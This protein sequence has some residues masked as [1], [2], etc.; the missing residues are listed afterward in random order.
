MRNPE[1]KS[2]KYSDTLVFCTMDSLQGYWQCPLAEEAREYFTSVAGD[3]LFTPTRVP[4]GVMN[5]ASYFQGMMMGVSGNLMRRACLIYIGDVKVI[6]RSVE[7]PM[8]KLKAVLLRLRSVGCSLRRTSSYCL[9]NRSN[10]VGNFTRERPSDTTQGVCVDWWRCTDQRR[11][12][13]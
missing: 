8:M 4:Q 6:W 12:M 7:E 10:G 1:I 2:E 5:A 13:S 11:W 3:G 9:P